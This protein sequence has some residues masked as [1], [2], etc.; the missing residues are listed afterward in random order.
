MAAL[1]IEIIPALSDNYVY[2][3]REPDSG[4]VAVIDPA[5]AEPVERALAAKGWTLTHILNTHHHNDHIGGN[6]A[7]VKAHGATLIGPRAETGRIPGMDVTVG[8]GD[9]VA[10]GDQTATVYETPGHTSG[11]ISFHFPDSAA[12]FCGDTL[13]AVGCG[14]MFEGTPEQF[15]ASLEKLRGLPDDTR[16]YC[17]HEYTQSNAR[18]ARSVLPDSEAL[19]TRAEAIDRL[20]AGGRRTIPSTIGEEKR[21]NPFLMAD[22]PAFA[23]SIGQ[24]GAPPSAVFAE[25]RRRKDSF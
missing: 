19:R 17:G 14:R 10:L 12:L 16:I 8:E 18:F 21:T 15:W 2:L 25:T 6:A 20:R 1:E 7:L 24:A 23:T 5:E 4:V 13:F 11:H 3:V 22:D 9:T